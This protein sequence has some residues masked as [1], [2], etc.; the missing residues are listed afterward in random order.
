MDDARSAIETFYDPVHNE[1]KIN[2]KWRLEHLEN[3]LKSQKLEFEKTK[4][5]YLFFSK[6]LT[7]AVNLKKSMM[8]AESDISTLKLALKK[9][10]SNKFAQAIHDIEKALADAQ[11][12]GHIKHNEQRLS[13]L[14]RLVKTAVQKRSYRF[15]RKC[16]GEAM[17]TIR[18][19]NGRQKKERGKRSTLLSSKDFVK[20]VIQTTS[21][22]DF[23]NLLA[24]QG[25][26]TLTF[27]IDDTGSM[28]DEMLAAKK[29]AEWIVDQPRPEPMEYILSPFNDRG[30][31]LELFL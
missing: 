30:N 10:N 28:W 29:T 8:Q 5:P 12:L 11:M 24:M 3:T 15:A 25:Q 21:V 4:R 16:I 22:S 2:L 6:N 7:A 20:S 27:A 13:K 14:R 31:I 1:S 26:V 17:F 9:S 23:N 19:I 18:K